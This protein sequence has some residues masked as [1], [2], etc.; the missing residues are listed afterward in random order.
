MT[1]CPLCSEFCAHK[2]FCG[3]RPD[4]AVIQR[5]RKDRGSWRFLPESHP[6]GD[7][8]S[9]LSEGKKFWLHWTSFKTGV[10]WAPLC[11]HQVCLLQNQAISQPCD[12]HTAC[13]W[14]MFVNLFWKYLCC[15]A[16]AICCLLFRQTTNTV[17]YFHWAYN[18]VECVIVCVTA[19]LMQLDWRQQR[20]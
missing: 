1:L 4:A 6:D 3:S 18:H 14:Y 10:L 8:S 19:T 15:K 11:V 17:R 20:N 13:S 2:D 12:L 16:V 9:S 7:R 5:E